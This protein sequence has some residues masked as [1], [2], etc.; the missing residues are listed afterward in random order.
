MAPFFLATVSL[1]STNFSGLNK[2]KSSNQSIFKILS[3][4]GGGIRGLYSAKLLEVFEARFKCRLVDYFDMICG[5]STGGLIALGLA[6]GIPA[7][8]ISQFYLEK[9]RE[10]FPSSKSPFRLLKQFFGTGKYRNQDLKRALQNI[11]S[12]KKLGDAE[13]LV[14]IP[15]HSITHARPYIFKFD[16][17]E[18]GLGRDNNTLVVDV[19]LATSAAPT[20]FPIVEIKDHPGQF[21]DG[22]VCANNPALVGLLEALM[23]FVGHNKQFDCARMLSIETL[24]P[25]S[26]RILSSRKSK[27][28]IH[29]RENLVNL[30]SEGQSKM[31]NFTMQQLCKSEF[32]PC[33]YVRIPSPDVSPQQAGLLSLDNASQKALDFLSATGI[34]Q[35]HQYAVRNEVRSFFETPKIY[36]IRKEKQNG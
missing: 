3:I 8:H 6:L 17:P 25:S 1:F 20:F 7:A 12:E 29:W 2:M 18:G 36:I 35:A 34:D 33:D 21:V 11:F 26:G 16:H 28:V 13:C 22:G 5:T 31:T 27:G 15:S 4:D 9:G 23:H 24:S 32:I 14:C 10:I 30:F 19:A